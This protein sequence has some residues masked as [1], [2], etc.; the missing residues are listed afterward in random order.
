MIRKRKVDEGCSFT[1][2]T[3]HILTI[4]EAPVKC[5][6]KWYRV[7][8]GN[9]QGIKIVE[10]EVNDILMM[11]EDTGLPGKFKVW[12]VEH[13]LIPRLAWP[14]L[15]YEISGTTMQRIGRRITR[16]IRKWIGASPNLSAACLYSVL[17][18]IH[19]AMLPTLK[20]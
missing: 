17:D 11:I 19:V 10:D 5:L 6:G 1:V 12:I 3:Q 18:A 16:C 9:Q 14:M 15:M 20:L 7:E 8:A 4:S 2:Q 13:G